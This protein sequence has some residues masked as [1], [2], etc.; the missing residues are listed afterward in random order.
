MSKT[1]ETKATPSTGDL[2][3]SINYKR[4]VE[5]APDI[6]YVYG[7][8]SGAK[9]WSPQVKDIL[10][11]SP[12]TLIKDPFAWVN[13]IHPEDQPKVQDLLQSLEHQKTFSIEYRVKDSKGNWHW[14][15]DRTT[16]VNKVGD[17]FIIEGMAQ[18]ITHHKLI[19]SQLQQSEEK[20][21]KAFMT[22]PDSISIS[23]LT[24][25]MYISVNEG[26]SQ[27]LGYDEDEVIGKTAFELN[28]WA[29]ESDRDKLLKLLKESGK[30]ES[31]E[32][33][34]VAKDGHTGVGLLSA[35]VIELNGVPHMLAMT[36]DISD[37]RNMSLALEESE[38]KYR[39]IVEN[40]NDGIEITLNNKIIY[41]NSRFAEM[42]GYT[43]D[44][45]KDVL[46]SHIFS[47][48]AKAD[49]SKRQDM[50]E[51]G[52][53]L[54]TTYQTTFIKKDGSIID[55]EVNYQIINYKNSAATFAIVRDVTES[56]KMETELRKLST[57]VEQSPSMIVITDLE[58]KIEY[59]NPIFCEITGYTCDEIKGKMT[60]I[61]KSGFLA[62]DVYKEL[63]NTITG[64]KI[65]RGEFRNKRKSG[66][67]YW[68]NA[69]I[70]PI[71]DNDGQ[72]THFLKVA[73]DVSEW[74]TI[75]EALKYSEEQYRLIVEKAN[76]GILISQNDQFIYRNSQFVG[77]LGY[78]EDEFEKIVQ[79]QYAKV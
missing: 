63:W 76:D 51:K 67:M 53:E 25:G 72:I 46:F 54:P 75:E 28:I 1:N 34:F 40:A 55:V 4:L 42:L 8:K 41:A 23:R 22:S 60:N 49:L 73:E 38:E 14:L 56:R 7:T 74:K 69:S 39:L 26:F 18:D 12:S 52:K 45:I 16:S 70:S 58:G 11:I 57:A 24:D 66:D 2:K 3:Y 19:E 50:R 32:A 13:A 30:V 59:V 6:S 62:D 35:S 20:F 78:T 47:D 64:G 29:D 33:V 61:L 9:F 36:H 44:E 31:F 10:G 79:K 68:E 37:L 27:I 48:E 77:M 65:W 71:T 5:T 21:R 17:E 43:Q 15:N